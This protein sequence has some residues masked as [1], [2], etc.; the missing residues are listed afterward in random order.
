ML[1]ARLPTEFAKPDVVGQDVDYVGFLAKP[2][3]ESREFVVDDIIFFLPLIG[4][5]LL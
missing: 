1:A 3:L 5:F 4:V 2:F